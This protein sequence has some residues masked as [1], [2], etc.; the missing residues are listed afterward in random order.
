[1]SKRFFDVGVSAV[2]LFCLSPLMF[3][4]ALLIKTT[5]K[6]PIIFKQERIGLDNVPFIILKFRTME[7]GSDQ[8]SNAVTKGDK[9]VTRIGAFF[10]STHL[11]ELPQ[12]VNVLKGEMSLVGPRPW[13]I[14]TMELRQRENPDLD[15][16]HRVRP[17]ITGPTQILGRT[18]KSEIIVSSDLAYAE[19]HS[20]INDLYIIFR[21]IPIV[22]KRKG[23]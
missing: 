18:L 19:E 2:L 20:L 8:S 15:Q 11:D 10:R 13:R 5:S 22:F 7:L 4:I 21:T 3:L 1:M 23:I 16:R 14:C 9:R 12:L 6:G 17:G